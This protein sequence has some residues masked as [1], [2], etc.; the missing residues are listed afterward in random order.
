MAVALFIDRLVVLV[1][2]WPVQFAKYGEAASVIKWLFITFIA[3]GCV[4]PQ[5]SGVLVS[6]A[7]NVL[8]KTVRV[9][10]AEPFWPILNQFPPAI[11][12]DHTLLNQ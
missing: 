1:I 3:S 10:C 9:P 12:L 11:T 8:L 5:L 4:L 7:S 6:G 2:V